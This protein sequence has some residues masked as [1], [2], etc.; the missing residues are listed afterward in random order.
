MISKVNM[1]FINK[2]INRNYK[3]VPKSREAYAIVTGDFVGEMLVYCY[4]D[5]ESYFF[6]SIPKNINRTVPIDKFH[7]A[8][9]NKI[10]EFVD[11]LPKQVFNI[12]FK[13][14]EYNNSKSKMQPTTTK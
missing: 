14:L 9:D 12:C 4:K 7:F 6:L 5:K 13:Q 11:V 2:L 10:A 1:E 3:K 8:I